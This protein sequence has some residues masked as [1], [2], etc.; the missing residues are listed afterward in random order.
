MEFE[1]FAIEIGDDQLIVAPQGDETYIIFQGDRELGVIE[2][3]WDGDNL[4][5]ISADLIE[6]D[7]VKQIGDAIES[8]DM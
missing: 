5:W 3:I 7:F 2:P 8:H 6:P 4:T 1:R